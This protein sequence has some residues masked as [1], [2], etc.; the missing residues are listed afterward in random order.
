MKDY[1]RPEDCSCIPGIKCDVQN[2][3]YN[4]KACHCTAESIIVTPDSTACAQEPACGTYRK[5]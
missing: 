2:C 5:S 3:V 4:D 1:C